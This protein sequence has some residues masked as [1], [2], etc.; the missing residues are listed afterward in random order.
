[1]KGKIKLIENYHLNLHKIHKL[2]E[3]ILRIHKKVYI[4][5]EKIQIKIH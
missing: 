5:L 2:P 3:K 1:M 4:I